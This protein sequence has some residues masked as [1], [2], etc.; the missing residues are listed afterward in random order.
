VYYGE[1]EID[2]YKNVSGK[3]ERGQ[4]DVIGVNVWIILK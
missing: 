4:L 2:E 3:P 1:G